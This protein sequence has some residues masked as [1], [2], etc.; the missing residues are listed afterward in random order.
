M[1]NEVETF[2]NTWENESK[3]T[4]AM[5]RS[6]PE[7]QYDFRPDSGGRSLGELAWHLSEVDGYMSF[8][9]EQGRFEMGVRPPGI[10]R[11]KS[12][13]E[14]APGYERVHQDAVERVRKLKPE[15]LD[16]KITFFTGDQPTVRE[17]LWVFLLHH[18]IHHRGQLSL[19]CRLAGGYAPAPYGPNR[20]QSAAMREKMAAA[21]K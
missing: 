15:D 1:S 21:A 7:G 2:L 10:E 19:M 8:G 6:L 3:S 4:I 20:E 17:I 9:I 13:A 11:P 18:M 14:L 5:L 12:I 16:R